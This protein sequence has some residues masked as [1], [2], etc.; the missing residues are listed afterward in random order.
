MKEIN[1]S[2]VAGHDYD[3]KI[4]VASQFS[5]GVL[6]TPSEATHTSKGA[7]HLLTGSPRSGTLHLQRHDARVTCFFYVSHG[8]VNETSRPGL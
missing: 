6:R 5:T 8:C 4:S 7:S 2:E 3:E 1:D